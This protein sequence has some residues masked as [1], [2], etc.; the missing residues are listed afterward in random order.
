MPELSNAYPTHDPEWI[1]DMH[2]DHYLQSWSKQGGRP[3]VITGA[4]GSW[5]LDRDGMHYT[6][7]LLE[8]VNT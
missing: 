7:S 3:R 8:L 5:F 2:A 4:S 6:E 1:R